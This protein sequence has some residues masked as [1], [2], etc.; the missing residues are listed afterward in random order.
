MIRNMTCLIVLL[1]GWAA[2]AAEMFSIV[3]L[4]DTQEY[5][6]RRTTRAV[7]R[8]AAGDERAGIFEE[9][10]RWIADNAHAMN[11]KMVVHLGD[12]TQ[13]DD[14]EEWALAKKAMDHLTG[15]V[16][17]CLCLGNH[18]MGCVRRGNG[19]ANAQTR[20]TN[21]GKFFPRAEVAKQQWFGG[22]FDDTLS[23][24]WTWFEAS[25]MKF[26]V[27]SLEFKPRDE[28][29]AWAGKVIDA[30]SEHRVILVTHAYLDNERNDNR[31]LT[32]ANYG[33][34]KVAG[35]SGEQMWEKLVSKYENIFMVLCGHV[36]GE[37]RRESKGDA[38]NTV[39]ELLADY[40]GLPNG[41]DGWL[42]YLVFHPEKDTIE[43]YTYS[44]KLDQHNEAASSRF[45][46]RYEMTGEGIGSGA[47]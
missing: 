43:V 38:G 11:T 15:K 44:P 12:I 18:D 41:G 28:V 16:P 35:N 23:N 1:V 20:E 7:E 26:M 32:E 27:M 3:A 22:S 47:R 46:L 10:T 17:T 6:D 24:Y 4:P 21:A 37:G 39:H 42:R 31:R 14:E 8:L 9:Q 45:T 34:Y 33:G 2:V 19:W 13:T 5:V 25:G 40:Q 30:H 29:L 36:L